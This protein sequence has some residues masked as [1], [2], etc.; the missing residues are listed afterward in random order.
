MAPAAG[1]RGAVI[2]LT[3]EQKDRL[4]AVLMK[5]FLFASL[6]EL[7]LII[8]AGAMTEVIAEPKQRVIEQRAIKQ[9]VIKQRGIKQRGFPI[10]QQL[11]DH[12][13]VSANYVDYAFVVPGRDICCTNRGIS[14]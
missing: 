11:I 14:D 2:T 9:R 6:E 7:D 1:L 13:E 12:T 5:P 4:M 10:R 3:D 8:V